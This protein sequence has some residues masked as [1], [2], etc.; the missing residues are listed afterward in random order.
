MTIRLWELKTGKELATISILSKDKWVIYTPEGRFDTNIDLEDDEI[1]HWSIPGSALKTLPLDVFMRDYYEPKL[2]ERLL[3]CT[4]NDTCERGEFRKVRSL[5]ELN[6]VRPEVRITEVSLPDADRQV[7]VTVEVSGATGMV[8][9]ENGQQVPRTT[10]VYDLRLFR[11]RQLV[12]D[13]PHDG[14]EKI[15]SR[16]AE[17]DGSEL[18]SR[19]ETELKIWREGTRINLNPQ[20]G[21]Q[22]VTFKVQLPKGQNAADTKFTAY[23]FNE[24][25][26]K[27]QTARYEW[28]AEQKALLPKADTNVKR[29]AYV[30]SVGVNY[31]RISNFKLIHADYDANQ[32]QTVVPEKLREAGVYEVVPV[33]LVSSYENGKLVL[34]ATKQHIETVFRMLAGKEVSLEAKQKI[35]NYER[36]EKTTPDDLIIVT[37]SSH[38]Y[39]NKNGDFYLLPSDVTRKTVTQ[40]IADLTSMISGEELALWLRDIEAD[41]MALIIDSCQAAA[42]VESLDFKPGPFGGRGFGQLAYDK[43]FKVL[44]ATQAGNYALQANGEIKGGLLTHAL[45]AEGLVDGVADAGPEKDGKITLNEWLNYGAGRVHKLYREVKQDEEKRAAVDSG[46]KGPVK[47]RLVWKKVSRSKDLDAEQLNLLQRALLF[48]F[49]QQDRDLLLFLTKLAR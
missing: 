27:S 34:K 48:N 20:T 41:E 21:K 2:F 29:R 46:K 47:K 42:A 10:G 35:P 43:Q 12:G 16:K 26:V 30:V 39:S 23:A 38:G 31:S 28:T 8:E 18:E 37:F 32:F 44:A 7:N 11:N 13:E 14:A 9:Q 17:I 25:R 1:L 33:R 49:A 4:E 19:F 45:V 15:A 36:I 40:K 5:S 3:N 22:A 24:D 6:I